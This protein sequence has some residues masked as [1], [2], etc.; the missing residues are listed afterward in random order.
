MWYDV[1]E[2]IKKKE[3]GKMKKVSIIALVLCVGGVAV[4][5]SEAWIKNAEAFKEIQAMCNVQRNACGELSCLADSVGALEKLVA[6][7][8]SCHEKVVDNKLSYASKPKE[9][10]E[11]VAGDKDK[12]YSGG[13]YSPDESKAVSDDK[14]KVDGKTENATE[15]KKAEEDT[16]NPD[17]EEEKSDEKQGKKTDEAND[18]NAQK[19]AEDEA[20][21]FIK[22]EKDDFCKDNV[23]VAYDFFSNVLS[24]VA[25]DGWAAKEQNERILHPKVQE[26][27]YAIIGDCVSF[28]YSPDFEISGEKKIREWD[29]NCL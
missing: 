18:V 19:R 3:R 4:Q 6:D 14:G 26:K 21:E 8:K 20:K 24:E 5:A 22:E 29:V 27:G 12:E 15:N 2:K 7:M 9:V 13:G 11:V 28:S 25:D 1:C 10:A 17:V 16:K 23:C